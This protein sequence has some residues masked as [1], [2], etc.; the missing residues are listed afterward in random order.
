MLGALRNS[1]TGSI[2]KSGLGGGGSKRTTGLPAA[3][4]LLLGHRGTQSFDAITTPSRSPAARGG[5][6]AG[7][8]IEAEEAEVVAAGEGERQETPRRPC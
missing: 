3:S 1:I 6:E 4:F 8:G 7:E 5:D 2:G